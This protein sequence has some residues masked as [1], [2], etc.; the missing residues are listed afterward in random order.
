[1]AAFATLAATQALSHNSDVHAGGNVD[2]AAVTIDDARITQGLAAQGLATNSIENHDRETAFKVFGGYQF[3]PNIALE[4]D[5]FS[6]G[7]FGYAAK[8]TPAGTLQGDMRLR[9]VGIDLVGTLP[10]AGN[11]SALGRIGVTST[12][13][14]DSFAATGAVTMPYSGMHPSQRSTDLKVGLG[15]AYAF[16]P[17]LS[18]RLEA[19]R[20]RF[21]DGVGNRGNADMISV[22]LVYRFGVQPQRAYVA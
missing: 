5:Y 15:L 17:A 21:K 9:G 12:R 2:R 6:L 7:H 13:A 22:G 18:L 3:N 4:A 16:T 20:Y 19:E 10:L 14:N 11:L 8:T 1:V